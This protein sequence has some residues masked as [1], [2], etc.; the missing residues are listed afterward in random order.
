MLVG[1]EPSFEVAVHGDL[2]LDTYPPTGATAMAA[3][4]PLRLLEPGLRAIDELPQHPS[5]L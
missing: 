2:F 4:R 1:G 5:Y 3:V